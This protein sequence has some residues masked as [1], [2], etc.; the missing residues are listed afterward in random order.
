MTMYIRQINNGDTS[1]S[2]WF[3]FCTPKLAG[4]FLLYL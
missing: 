1:H 2:I 3:S 4:V